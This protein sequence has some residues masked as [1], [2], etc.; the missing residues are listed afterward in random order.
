[1]RGTSFS[2]IVTSTTGLPLVVERTMWWDATGYGSHTERAVDGPAK[3]WYFAEGSQGFFSTY[4]LLANP[5]SSA[6]SANVT[7]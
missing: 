2:T 5:Q 3:T 7:I 6:N 4:V 1:M